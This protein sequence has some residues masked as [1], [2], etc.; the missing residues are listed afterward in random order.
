MS[1]D[2]PIESSDVGRWERHTD[3]DRV[4]RHHQYR[5]RRIQSVLRVGVIGLMV[6]AMLVGTSRAE[7]AKQSILLGFYGFMALWAV[8]SAFLPAERSRFPEVP[9][10]L[11]SLTDVGA[12]FAFEL[13][14]TGGYFPLAI[15]VLLP[16]LT[17][18][19]VLPQRA[20]KI[21][22]LSVAAFAYAVLA[23][24][25]L[26]R[27]LSWSQTA[28]LIAMYGFA[29]VAAVSLVYVRARY[30]DEIA[31]L[32]VAR[33]ELL[34]DTMT[35]AETER[36]RISESIHDGPLQDVLFA[37][38][39]IVD[40]VARTSP[41]EELD[42]VL[43]S[44]AH[45][46]QQLREATFELHPAV[47]EQTGLAAA[48]DGLISATVSRSGI[49]IT[50]DIDYPV[51]NAIDPIVFGVIRE[52]L[53]NVVRHSGADTAMVT[54]RVE[55]H[56]CRVDVT[57]NGVGMSQDRLAERLAEGH[58][59]WVSHRAR[60]EAAGGALTLLE[61]AVGTHVRVVLPIR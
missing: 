42:R 51:K 53:S 46:S 18:L 47:L 17:S 13:L 14:S 2:S 9:G 12:V 39:E 44:L 58:I 30:A 60:V 37:R 5:S 19:Y 1:S 52:L 55:N 27:S 40:L 56:L 41:V 11:L 22:A 38:Q 49:V 3:L 31:L 7:W 34:A 59:G 36:R 23:D 20:A 33:E 6:I 24:P 57:D 54:V 15:M 25:I 16:M 48:V 28:F 8:V 29:C 21:M 4:R 61:T 50:S 35:A 10:T 32:T 45:T 26:D 43:A